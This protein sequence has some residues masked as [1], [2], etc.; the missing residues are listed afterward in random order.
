[1]LTAI[2]LGVAS[3]S[4]AAESGSWLVRARG[5][6][7]DPS[8]SSTTLIEVTNG[9]SAN[10]PGT[11]KSMSTAVMPE[12]EAVYFFM[13]KVAVAVNLT[14][15]RHHL[16]FKETDL[17]DF[18]MGKVSMLPPSLTLQYHFA[19]S[20]KIS[21]YVGAGINYTAFYDVENGSLGMPITYKDSWGTVLQAG[22]DYKLT[23]HWSLN[24]DVKK[25]FV[26]SDVTTQ[27]PTSTLHTTMTFNPWLVGVGLGYRA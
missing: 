15:T 16:M 9:V 23:S 25:V 18:D 13:P 17:G 5:L 12:L 6:V 4:F 27:F 8:P 19:P 21:P 14:T 10:E 20:S 7:V 22:V 26:N 3:T 24:M 1:M 2:A 11:V